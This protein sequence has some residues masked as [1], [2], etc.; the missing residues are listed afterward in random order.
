MDREFLLCASGSVCRNGRH[1]YP[2]LLPAG[3]T[4]KVP[5]GR[6]SK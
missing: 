3:S 5:A 2:E 4:V 6:A 1:R